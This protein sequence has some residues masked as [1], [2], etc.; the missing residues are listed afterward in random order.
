V[1]VRVK[2]LDFL[3]E[4]LESRREIGLGETCDWMSGVK[5]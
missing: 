2:N 3:Q 1:D 4:M 5:T